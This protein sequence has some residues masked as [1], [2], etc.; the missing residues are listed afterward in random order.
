MLCSLYAINNEN[1]LLVYAL[2]IFYVANSK[3]IIVFTIMII[4]P[5][6]LPA[7]S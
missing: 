3:G 6:N 1:I 7:F 2:K 4:D 5:R